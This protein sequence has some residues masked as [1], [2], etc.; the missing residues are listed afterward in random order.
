MISA[1]PLIWVRNLSR[2]FFPEITG[3][4]C[5]SLI[6]LLEP[7]RHFIFFKDYG[8]IW[9]AAYRI[10]LGQIPFVDFST[11]VGPGSFLIPALFFDL[12]GTSWH[13]LQIS[14]LSQ[15]SILLLSAYFILKKTGAHGVNLSISMLIFASLYLIFLSHPWYN[16][17]ATLFF[18]ISLAVTLSENRYAYF[19]AGIFS[20]FSF[21][22]K[23]DTGV[24][25]LIALSL[26][27]LLINK[28]GLRC[29][30]RVINLIQSLVGTILVIFGFAFFVGFSTFNTWLLN[31]FAL[32]LQRG[33]GWSELLKGAPILI[34]GIICFSQF[35]FTKKNF[36]LYASIVNFS[37]FIGLQTKALFF[38]NFYYT[39]FTYLTLIYF[40]KKGDKLPLIF[41][42]ALTLLSTFTPII[43][44]INLG[45]TTF[46]GVPEPYSLKQTMVTKPVIISP[47]N[48]RVLGGVWA[49]PETF[50]AI[51]EITRISDAIQS[52]SG[53][54]PSILNISE[55]TP[56]YGEIG[57]T[58]P[59]K[60][61]L[62]FD[63]K[64]TI[65]PSDAL[66]IKQ[67]LNSSKF[68]IVIL[69]STFGGMN[70]GFYE[71]VLEL[72]K[73]N[74]DYTSLSED[75]YYSPSSSLSSCPSKK[76]CLNH[77]LFIFT[78]K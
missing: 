75:G 45:Q 36:L 58:P 62:W 49:P 26:I 7:Y 20:G 74:K 13:S 35:L 41:V 2:K 63:P 73:N 72:M 59:I 70:A 16:S 12:M 47:N 14:Q 25:N 52:K 64:L 3:I 65:S 46:L 76:E 21:L 37:A 29:H 28:E 40:I 60:M 22:T 17:T 67:Q 11:P 51:E 23:Q 71:P 1:S 38:T 61:P 43:S 66:H 4:A 54:P 5:L 53:V 32:A 31:S 10:Y 69:Q 6:W 39:L 77:N 27:S 24:F 48:L 9:E 34:L 68:D 8:I 30:S 55:L 57:E 15:S 78:R 56:I 50:Q 19:L 33:N 42:T 18:F 44:L